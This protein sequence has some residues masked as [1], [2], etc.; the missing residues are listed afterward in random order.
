MSE[1][2]I[3]GNGGSGDCKKICLLSQHSWNRGVHEINLKLPV[4]D[5]RRTPCSCQQSYVFQKAKKIILFLVM[6]NK[7]V[8]WLADTNGVAYTLS[9]ED[10]KLTLRS[11]ET[12]IIKRISAVETCAFAIGGD[13]DVYLYVNS[14]DVPIRVQVSTYENQRWTPIYKWSEKSVSFLLS[15]LSLYNFINCCDCERIE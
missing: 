13:Q 8:I 6:N 5:F 3:Y 11:E 7:G 14:R 10:N 2:A 9:P 4:G 1:S 15:N 12:D